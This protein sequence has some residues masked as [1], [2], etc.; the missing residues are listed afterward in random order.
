MDM[1]NRDFTLLTMHGSWARERMLEHRKV[2]KGFMG[3]ESVRGESS[4]Q[5]HPFMALA[6]GNADQSQGE[7]YTI[8][9]GNIL[10]R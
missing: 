9:K 4:H 10:R 1:D 3:V 7:V 8:H 5:E 6:A 2:K